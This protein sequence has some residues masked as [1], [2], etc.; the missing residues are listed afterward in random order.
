MPTTASYSLLIVPLQYDHTPFVIQANRVSPSPHPLPTVG[1]PSEHQSSSGIASGSGSNPFE[2]PSENRDAEAIVPAASNDC[3]ESGE[4]GNQ[5]DP[6]SLEE[7]QTND[8]DA[9]DGQEFGHGLDPLHGGHPQEGPVLEEPEVEEQ[10]NAFQMD[11][12]QKTIELIN[13][14]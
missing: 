1:L 10:I 3:R 8:T 6:G 5:R 11:E 12:V 14:I 2:L 7:D 9:R 13:A 4:V